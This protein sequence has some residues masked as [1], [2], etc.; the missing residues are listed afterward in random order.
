MEQ[1]H[2]T[3]PLHKIISLRNI[4]NVVPIISNSFRIDQIFRD[5]KRLNDLIPKK[6]RFIDDDLTLNEQLTRIWAKQIQYPMAE[7]YKLWQVAQYYQVEQDGSDVAKEDYLEFLKKVLLDINEGREGYEDFVSG[8]R[9]DIHTLSFSE[10]VKG[11][12]YP[13]FPEAAVDPLI[14]L[15]QMPFPV[16]ITTSPHD[17]LERAL[18]YENKKPHTQVLFWEPGREYDDAI[19]QKHN[20]DPSFN[21]TATNPAVYHLFG[22]E[23]YPGSLLISE[24]DYLKFL[25]S[26]VS[27]T[28]TQKPVVPHRLRRALASSHLLLIGYHLRDWDFRVLFRFILNYRQNELAKQGICIQLKPKKEN[29]QILKY[30]RRYFNMKKFEIEWKSSEEFIQELLHVWKDHQP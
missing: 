22:L 4:N 18:S 25:V 14:I 17:F 16:Y 11:L 23:N 21:P 7:D 10:L 6:S 28:D 8:H 3:S 1:N 12:D 27:D 15:A 13:Q 24:D 26:V 2:S 30:L 5:S 9:K 20:P 19:L 29:Q